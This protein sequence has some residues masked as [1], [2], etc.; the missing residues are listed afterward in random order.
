MEVG[1]AIA[2]VLQQPL[3]NPSSTTLDSLACNFGDYYHDSTNKYI[4][5]CVSDR[6]RN[7]DEIKVNTLNCL[8]FCDDPINGVDKE[9]FVRSWNNATQW[10]GLVN[11]AAGAN[12]TIP[13][14]WT[15]KLD[16]D[17]PAL[18]SLIIEGNLFV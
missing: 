18:N 14:A 10:P 9:D 17:P 3:T 8:H 13:A 6:A 4:F 16:V 1:K 2:D 7:Y 5:V 11:P 12:V 15:V